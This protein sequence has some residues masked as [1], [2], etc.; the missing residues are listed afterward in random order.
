MA[1]VAPEAR[2]REA[3]LDHA[4]ELADLVD[5]AAQVLARL[6]CR[7]RN[8]LVE[9]RGDVGQRALALGRGQARH[10]VAAG[11]GARGE[12]LQ[13]LVGGARRMHRALGQGAHAVLD[14]FGE[15]PGAR[16]RDAELLEAGAEHALRRVLLAAAV[17]LH[18]AADVLALLRKVEL[19]QQPAEVVEHRADVALLAVAQA[20]AAG[21]LARE[22]ARQ[23]GAQELLLQLAGVGLVL[24]VLEEQHGDRDVAHRVEAEHHHRARDRA[25]ASAAGGAEVRRVHHPQQLV[26]EAEVAQ[27]QRRQRAHALGFARRDAV[28]RHHRFGQRGK[29]A[30]MLHPAHQEIHR[31][32]LGLGLRIGFRRLTPGLQREAELRGIGEA[33]E[34]VER[35]G[36]QR[37]RGQR[38][39]DRRAA[40]RQGDRRGARALEDLLHPAL[41]RQR[42][43]G[44]QL[45]QQHARGEHVVARADLAALDVLGGHVARGAR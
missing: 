44:E 8:G 43:P 3:H 15:A 14:Q 12:G 11:V 31:A 32:G 41:A 23:A 24:Q 1:Q 20:Q 39:I 27:D 45:D 30:A 40:G 21:E 19:A 26:G 29:V 9:T 7:H 18:D 16:E 17:L 35:G 42:A 38:L 6:S 10:R 2:V 13:A 4:G 36:A 33:G 28:D 22:Q 25:D 34:R 37:D 5:R